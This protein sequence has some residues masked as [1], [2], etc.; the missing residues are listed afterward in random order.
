MPQQ[1]QQK[2]PPRRVGVVQP[3]LLVVLVQGVLLLLQ[4]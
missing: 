2:Q 3:L 4:E 1:P